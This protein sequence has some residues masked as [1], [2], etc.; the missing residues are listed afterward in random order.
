MA[1]GS[2]TPIVTR[3]SATV[4]VES[5]AN[6]VEIVD[7]TDECIRWR[8][9]VP[10]LRIRRSAATGLIGGQEV[11]D[12]EEPRTARPTHKRPYLLVAAEKM[13]VLSLG[14]GASGIEWCSGSRW[15]G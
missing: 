12:R 13:G 10:S 6:A 14:S 15:H 7:A 5:A 2:L 4:S 3:Y 9:S 1:S 8:P 11:Q